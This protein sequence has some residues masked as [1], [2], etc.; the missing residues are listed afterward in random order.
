MSKFK[1]DDLQVDIDYLRNWMKRNN[2]SQREFA[3]KAGLHESTMSKVLTKY[4]E[5]TVRVKSSIYSALLEFGVTHTTIR[6]KALRT[7]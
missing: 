6:R 7:A 2:V 1:V 4:K 5:P 3:A